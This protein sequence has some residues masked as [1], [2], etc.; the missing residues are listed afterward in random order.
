V[1]LLKS[2]S[3][4]SLFT[5]ASRITGLVRD[6]LIAATFGASALTDAYNI[7]FRIPN[8][9]R[10]FFAEGAFSQAFVPSFGYARTLHGD[11]IAAQFADKVATVL[12]WFLVLVCTVGVIG[13]PLLVWLM[14]SGLQKN[15]QGY[16]VA[17]VMTRWMFPYLGLISLAGLSASVLNTYKRFAVPAAAPVLLNLSMIM[18][19]WLLGPWFKT[20]G[21][22]PIF[23]LAAGV[24]LGGVLQL[25]LQLTALA[26]I[27]RLPRFG[28]RWQAIKDAWRDESTKSVLRLM[29]PAM[30]GVSVA[31]VSLLINTQIASRLAT[32]SVTWLSNADRLMEFPT[33]LLGVALGVVLMPRL[34]AAKAAGELDQYSAMLDWGLRL[35]LVLSLPCAVALFLFNVPLA[36]TLFHYGAYTAADVVQTSRALQTYGVGLLGLVAVK[37]LASGFYAGKDIKTP[38]KIG[39]AVLL[40]TQLLNLVLVPRLQHAG[41]ALS[42]GLGALINALW[43]LIGLIKQGAFKP[44]P[45]WLVFILQVVVATSLMGLGLAWVGPQF[46]WLAPG[47]GKLAR[48]GALAGIVVVAV[49]V[50]FATLVVVGMR[51]RR[52]LRPA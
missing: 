45:G 29:G 8:M 32:G 48:A 25:G 20:I 3:T 46:D 10:R 41:L 7:A 21:I 38:V 42:I 31:Q 49:I 19:T 22:E 47:S 37:V 51:L 26:R 23:A 34:S 35:V 2:T 43:L 13:A 33:A 40:M 24:L 18:A 50:Y 1:S 4:V 16:D 44:Q 39:I 36:A 28:W 5:L 17:V 6:Q 52:L 11:E 27:G 9:F 12:L 15:P 14:A 30:L